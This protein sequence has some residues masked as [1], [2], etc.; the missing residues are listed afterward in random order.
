MFISLY[1]V[2]APEHGDLCKVCCTK[3]PCHRD[4]R[5]PSLSGPQTRISSTTTNLQ[6]CLVNKSSCHHNNHNTLSLNSRHLP[7]HDRMQFD[8]LWT[9]EDEVASGDEDQQ[10]CMAGVLS[11]LEGAD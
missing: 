5:C 9:H 1:K 4:R 11:A 3:R 7:S 2:H 8:E 6:H 10:S